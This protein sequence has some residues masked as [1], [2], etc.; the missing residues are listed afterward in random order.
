MSQDSQ[1]SQS[2]QELQ[3]KKRAR[4]RLVG[5]IGLVLL[6]ITILPLLLKDKTEQAASKDILI[7]IP[8]QDAQLNK[9]EA[10]QK[11]KQ[12]NTEDQT[13]IQSQD[14]KIA[15]T[16]TSNDQAVEELKPL[17]PSV[18]E[19]TNP[20]AQNDKATAKPNTATVVSDASKNQKEEMKQVLSDAP[21][22][23]EDHATN[24]PTVVSSY[25]VQIGVFSSPDNVKQM[26][27]KLTSKG[28][29]T[30]TEL[31]DTPKGKKTR[32]R[33]G[34]FSSRKDAESALDKV[35]GLGLAGMVI[36]N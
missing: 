17:P 1:Q 31:I 34:A 11:V 5:A 26:Q 10:E 7:S 27:S 29:K 12:Q 16:A 22:K 25:F 30:S 24:D 35:K 28:L 15:S 8:S 36:G 3:F 4:R 33:V 13:S 6:M 21:N 18:V 2:E 14:V 23:M 19:T 32:L 20:V 9:Q